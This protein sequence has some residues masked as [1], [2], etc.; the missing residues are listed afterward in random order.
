MLNLDTK[1][2]KK[3]QN[4]YYVQYNE[5]KIYEADAY[6]GSNKSKSKKTLNTIEKMLRESLNKISL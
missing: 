5:A 6:L 2:L 3:L 1:D 4:Q